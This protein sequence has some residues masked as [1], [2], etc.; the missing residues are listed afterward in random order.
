MKHLL[1]TLLLAPLAALHAADEPASRPNIIVIFTDDQT[2]R[3]IGYN[4]PEMDRLIQDAAVEMDI[5]KRRALLERANELVAADRV[6]LPIVSVGSAW[7][8]Q[9]SRVTLAPRVDEDTL[10]MD[11]KPV[12]R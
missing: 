10:A 4:N 8:M 2:Y 3:G 6:R 12:A 1:T 7:A 11:I 9:K 5:D